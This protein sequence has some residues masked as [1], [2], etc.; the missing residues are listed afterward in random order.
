MSRCRIRHRHRLR[1]ANGLGPWYH[2]VFDVMRQIPFGA[3]GNVYD[4]ALSRPIDFGVAPDDG[5]AEFDERSDFLIDVRRMFRM[6]TA[7]RFWWA[8]LMLKEWTANRRSIERY[9]TRNAVALW[10]K[11][12]SDEASST[13]SACFGPWIGSDRTRVSLHQAG[14]FFLKQLTSRP[15]RAHPADAEGQSWVHG[16]R[17]G[18]L[19][20]RGPSSEF[21]FDPWIQHL[22]TVGVSFHWN[23]ALHHFDYDGTRITAAHLSSGERVDADINVFA[24]NPFATVDIVN[25]SPALARIDQLNL[26]EPLVADG[27]H[28]QV[29]FRVAFSERIAWPR[30]RSAVVIAASEFDLTIFAEEQ[31]W[32]PAV[33]LGDGISSLWTGIACVSSVPG[34]VHGLPVEL[35]SKQ[36]FID[37]VTAQLL[38]C[39]SLNTLIQQAN[40]GRPWT[41]F[42]SFESK[43]GPNGPF[44]ATGYWGTIRNGSTRP[45]RSRFGRPNQPRSQTSYSQAHTR[46]AP[47]TRGASRQPSRA[48][49]A[50]R[51]SS[52]RT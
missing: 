37:E 40:C 26:F 42:R 34:R 4:C 25:R 44:R 41:R 24:T 52:N 45:T 6:T 33:V 51:R 7:D 31:A 12:L 15:S 9:A 8:R 23:Q 18:W 21:W 47:P 43:S 36:Q 3:N 28:V 16:S 30:P 19:L 13:W 22:T 49:D 38:R 48:D 14:Q 1:I 2:N 17:S 20:L 46:A 11:R 27:P 5:T 35:C 29:S 39:G 50:L 10:G 32:S